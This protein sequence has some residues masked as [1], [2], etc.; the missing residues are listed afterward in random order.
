MIFV[1][2]ITPK[3]YLHDLVADHTDF[4][5]YTSESEKAITAPGL[6]CDDDEQVVTVPFISSV[7]AFSFLLS[8][9]LHTAISPVYNFIPLNISATKDVR[10]PPAMMI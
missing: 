8:N 2:S 1:F 10:G 9:D 5:G 7:A 4:Y 3:K 6:D